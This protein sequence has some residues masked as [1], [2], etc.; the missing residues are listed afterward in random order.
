MVIDSASGK[1]T[2][3]VFDINGALPTLYIKDGSG[4]N[5]VISQ[6]E[7]ILVRER[8]PLFIQKYLSGG[9]LRLSNI[10]AIRAQQGTTLQDGDYFIIEIKDATLGNQK[11]QLSSKNTVFSGKFIQS[12]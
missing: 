12:K 10:K 4:C 5:C 3:P 7:F 6:F 1:E 8:R 2:S 11:C 9:M